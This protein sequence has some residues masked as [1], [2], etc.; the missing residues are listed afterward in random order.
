MRGSLIAIAAFSALAFVA[1]LLQIRSVERGARVAPV[2]RRVGAAAKEASHVAVPSGA[3]T[4]RRLA[5]SPAPL[6]ALHR[7][8][9]RLLDGDSALEARLAALGGYPVVLNAWASWCPPCR[10]EMPLFANAAFAFGRRVAFLGADV[11]DRPEEARRM[12]A[13]ERLSYPSYAAGAGELDAIA[14]V[15]GTPFTV[16]LDRRG[17]VAGVHVGAYDSRSALAADVRSLLAQAGGTG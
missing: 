12:L 8:A 3:V 9:G 7:Q 4:R 15:R 13:A 11:D 5:G 1:I 17:E 6:A 10:E 2:A 14:P 16:F